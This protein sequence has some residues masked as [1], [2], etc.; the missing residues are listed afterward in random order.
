MPILSINI[1]LYKCNILIFMLM[2][3]NH[4]ILNIYVEHIQVYNIYY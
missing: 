4:V 1:L 3:N 2:Y